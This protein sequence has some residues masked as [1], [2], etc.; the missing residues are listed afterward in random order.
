MFRTHLRQC[1]VVVPKDLHMV[2]GE[3]RWI[4]VVHAYLIKVKRGGI[5]TIK[6]GRTHLIEVDLGA[7][8]TFN[9]RDDVYT[10]KHGN[11]VFMSYMYKSVDL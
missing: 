8:Y 7:W 4:K 6:V 9:D 1:I 3:S 10:L 5:Y 2:L 11:M